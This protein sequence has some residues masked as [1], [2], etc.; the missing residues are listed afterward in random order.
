MFSIIANAQTTGKSPYPVIFV[1]GL[2]SSDDKW[3][4]TINDDINLDLQDVYGDFNSFCTY[5]SVLNASSSST[6]LEDD[7]E[8]NY[9][10]INNALSSTS[11]LFA[12]NFEASIDANGNLLLY[13]AGGGIG[14]TASNEAAIYKQ[15][16][17]LSKMIDKVLSVTGADK[18][19][20]VGHSMG[21][22]AIRE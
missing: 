13:D 15:A 14:I 5:H 1:H 7:V 20:L 8:Y 4:S 6:K 22:L 12:I 18:V 17:A 10:G 16:Y 11:S 2:N 9:N 19:I 3:Y 21:G